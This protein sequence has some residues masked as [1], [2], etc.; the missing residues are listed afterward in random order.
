MV[1]IFVYHLTISLL[2]WVDK[3]MFIG[4]T[5]C[6]RRLFI[7][8]TIIELINEKQ[9]CDR[10]ELHPVENNNTD[11]SYVMNSF[12]KPGNCDICKKLLKGIFF[13]VIHSLEIYYSLDWCQFVHWSLLTSL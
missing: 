2:I 13:Q 12:P 3:F 1:V 7:D 10:D 8:A 4:S 9:L 5:V 6:K 11:H